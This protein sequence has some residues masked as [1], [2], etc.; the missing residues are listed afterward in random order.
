[1]IP[2]FLNVNQIFS[3]FFLIFF[4][5]FFFLTLYL[6]FLTVLHDN[7]YVS[8]TDTDSCR[9]FNIDNFLMRLVY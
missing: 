1:M 4:L 2:K 5:F 7:I 6:I 8:V 3:L 9:W